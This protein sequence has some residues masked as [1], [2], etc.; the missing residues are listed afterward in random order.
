MKKNMSQ[1]KLLVLITSILIFNGY[2]FSEI[3][4][5]P[6]RNEIKERPM[7]IELIQRIGS[8][9]ENEAFFNPRSFAVD[10][11]GRI[12]ILDTGNSRIQCFSK[13]GRF[14]FTFGRRGQGPGELSK[15]ASSIKILADGNIYVI[16][17]LQ[18]R[19]NVYGPGGKF[20]FSAKT[21]VY[22]NDIV[23][24][25]KTYYLSS[26]RLQENYRPID[27]STTLGKIDGS[28]GI[29]IEP[30]IGLVKEVSK[31]PNP[32]AWEM[33][34][35]NSNFTKIIVD[36]NNE[37]IFSQQF[38]YRLIKY[39]SDGRVLKDVFGDVNFDTYGHF[40]FTVYNV[41]NAEVSVSNS[42]SAR[43]LDMSVIGDNL[44]L[45]PYL[46]PEK[47]LFFID[48]YDLDLNLIARQKMPNSIVNYKKEEAMGQMII[49]DNNNMYVL[50]DSQ[51]GP[52]QL[53]KYKLIFN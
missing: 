31:L 30:A 39:N 7:R 13:E 35:S 18:R 8:T 40:K 20:L 15:D 52:P 22:Y 51:E 19:I 29:L 16:D 36:K 46:N 48:I 21:S 27:T 45:V 24:L 26:I 12:F 17:N 32:K 38:P 9:K 47:D 23:L 33:I 10:R 44:L 37:I 11:S 50:L 3:A 25:N 41:D 28:F 4:H 2:G 5:W 34:F 6:N 1:T 43:V 49:D 53:V 42:K 14:Q